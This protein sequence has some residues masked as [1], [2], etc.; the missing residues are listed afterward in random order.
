MYVLNLSFVK[1]VKKE[2]EK[3]SLEKGPGLA[4]TNL[5]Q[6]KRGARSLS[7]NGW[8]KEVKYIYATIKEGFDAFN[9]A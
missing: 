6:S 9:S 2:S 1:L 5:D 8:E 4:F 7:K 3:T